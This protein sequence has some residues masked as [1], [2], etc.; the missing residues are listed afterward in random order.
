MRLHESY[1]MPRHPNRKSASRHHHAKLCLSTSSTIAP[2]GLDTDFKIEYSFVV[3][4]CSKLSGMLSE[5]LRSNE[6]SSSYMHKHMNVIHRYLHVGQLWLG[7]EGPVR[8]FRCHCCCYFC[9]RW[10]YY[11]RC[12]SVLAL[13]LWAFESAYRYRLNLTMKLVIKIEMLFTIK[14]NG[15]VHTDLLRISGCSGSGL[16]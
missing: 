6:E 12:L 16:W 3:L 10:C 2:A 4:P 1:Y 7:S 14:D 5:H 15:F 11:D 8:G 13:W 9:H